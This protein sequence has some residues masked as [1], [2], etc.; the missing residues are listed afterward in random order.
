MEARFYANSA[1]IY[2]W[3]I[4]KEICQEAGLEDPEETIQQ[5]IAQPFL[6]PNSWGTDAQMRGA[7][8]SQTIAVYY[9]KI[10][11]KVREA[12][13]LRMV[14]AA[15]ISGRP[16]QRHFFHPFMEVWNDKVRIAEMDRWSEDPKVASASRNQHLPV[17]TSKC[18]ANDLAV[19][20]LHQSQMDGAV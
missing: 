3:Q 2:D 12:F 1:R 16:N 15:L 18:N 11:E 17:V 20:P 8:D 6:G 10:V 14:D 5:A 19:P 7:D 9:Y 13:Q 4:R